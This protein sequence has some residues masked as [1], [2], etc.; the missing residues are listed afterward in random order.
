[1]ADLVGFA[2]DKIEV[3]FSTGTSFTTPKTISTD[4][5]RAKTWSTFNVHPRYLFDYNGDGKM[6]IIGSAASPVYGRPSNGRSSM[7][8]ANSF[9]SGFGHRDSSGDY[10]TQDESPRWLGDINGDGLMD[11]VAFGKNGMEVALG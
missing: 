7:G 9:Y 4:L 1:M 11:I 3:S 6:D 8:S 2:Q 10:D 5:V